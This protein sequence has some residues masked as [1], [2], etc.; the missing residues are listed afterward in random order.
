MAQDSSL[1]LYCHQQ[2]KST[3]MQRHKQGEPN[4]LNVQSRHKYNS[5]QMERERER[6]R[7]TQRVDTEKKLLKVQYDTTPPADLTPK[8]ETKQ[9][10][11]RNLTQ[12]S[13]SSKN[14]NFAHNPSFIKP[15]RSEK[16]T[17]QYS[18]HSESP[19][20][21]LQVEFNT[22]LKKIHKQTM[23]RD[24][25]TI[26]HNIEAKNQS[27]PAITKRKKKKEIKK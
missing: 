26:C 13:K 16:H 7:E 25:S 15:E 10:H 21:E 27:S 11:L 2:Q 22:Q 23:K 17:N 24:Q 1:P 5:I 9:T 12:K 6:E 8:D 4:S 3:K 18:N 14:C 20:T 19:R